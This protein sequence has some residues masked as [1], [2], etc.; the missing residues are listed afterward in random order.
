MTQIKTIGIL[1]QTGVVFNGI[2]LV[3][4]KVNITLGYNVSTQLY[5]VPEQ[6]LVRQIFMCDG[7]CKK[8]EKIC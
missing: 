1:D 4:K 5:K 6:D 8:T 3:A 2:D 7:H